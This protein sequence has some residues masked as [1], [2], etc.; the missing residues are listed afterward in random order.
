MRKFAARFSFPFND[1][2]FHFKSPRISAR[3]I[4]VTT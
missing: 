3:E 1:F 4:P 2:A